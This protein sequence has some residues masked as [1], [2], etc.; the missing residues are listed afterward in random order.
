VLLK[1]KG[2]RVEKGLTQKEMS[3]L[4]NIETAT[5]TRKENG[6]T[7][8]RLDEINKILEILQCK[9]EDIF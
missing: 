1:L 5:Y 6:L 4:L 7:Q 8:F 2:K 3:K 9:F